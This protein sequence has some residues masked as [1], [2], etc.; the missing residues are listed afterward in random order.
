MNFKLKDLLYIA[1]LLIGMVASYF[2]AQANTAGEI[3]ALHL[4]LDRCKTKIAVNETKISTTE[5]DVEK[6]YKNQIKQNE[7]TDK[8]IELV[9][10]L[11]H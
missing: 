3:T 8:I 10:R 9:Y 6:I 11:A 1:T 2:T 4:E 7:K 5:K